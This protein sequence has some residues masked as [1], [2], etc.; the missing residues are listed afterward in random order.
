MYAWTANHPQ[1]WGHV[2]AT[3][4]LKQIVEQNWSRPGGGAQSQHLPRAHL[5]LDTPLELDIRG[6]DNNMHYEYILF[7]SLTLKSEKS[8]EIKERAH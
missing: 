6:K 8:Q 5:T 4:K 3:H 2:Y 7:L 1:V